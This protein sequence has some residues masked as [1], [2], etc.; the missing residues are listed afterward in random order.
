MGE[1]FEVD[2]SLAYGERV[3]RLDSLGIA[4]RDSLQACIRPGSLDASI[5]Q[6]VVNDFLA[7]FAT[8]PNITHIYFNG[9]K[10]E[11]KRRVLPI[12]QHKA[13]PHLPAIK[14]FSTCEEV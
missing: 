14:Q 2:L 7:F 1:L 12:S 5:R 9:R 3:A 13:R 6:E 11:T 10:P 4:L 8:Y